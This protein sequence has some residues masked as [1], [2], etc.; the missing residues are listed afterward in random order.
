MSSEIKTYRIR[1]YMLIGHDSAPEWRSFTRE[2]RAVSIRDALEKV[3]SELGSA[4]KLKRSMI[5]IVS[6]DEIKPEEARSRYV[7][8]LAELS[9]IVV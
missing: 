2:V 7:K 5:K 6:V 3:Y 8:E 9:M 4:H 1:G